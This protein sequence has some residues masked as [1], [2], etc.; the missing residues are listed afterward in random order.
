MKA[1]FRRLGYAALGLF[2]FLVVQT[3]LTSAASTPQKPTTVVAAQIPASY[4]DD[5]PID[6]PEI[7]HTVID[8]YERVS[9]N[10]V[11]ITARAEQ[12]D[13]F[14]R[15]RRVQ[16]GGSGFVI[17]QDGHIVTNHHVVRGATQLDVTLAD[18]S[19]YPGEVLGVDGVNDLA[20]VRLQA[21]A[22]TIEELSAVPLGA[23]HSLQVG[24]TVVAIGNPYGLER[25]A[26]KGIVSSLG[27]VRT[28]ETERQ[29]TNM[30]QTDAAINPGNS[31]GPLLNLSGEVIGINEQ[32]HV[33][34]SR[35]NIGIG[36][37][38]PVDTLVRY[39][40]DLLEGSE[41]RHAWLG[42][43]GLS[44][45]SLMAERHGLPV[46]RG[47]LVTSVVDGG[48]AEQAGLIAATP[49]GQTLD[50]DIVTAIDG[51]P[52]RK[53][54]DIAAYV[55]AAEPGWVVTLSVVR[56]GQA[57]QVPVSLGAWEDQGEP[58]GD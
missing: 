37:A 6:H 56:N 20:V 40:P 30:I 18:G 4:P 27:R 29:I 41:P 57:L 24:E 44:V 34:G 16:S 23:S 31:G 54:E 39:L 51:E 25:S 17:D 32:I 58:A 2:G 53:A 35:G 49:S 9:P 52:V 48:P 3:L 11:N 45:T 50:A 21:P 33:S 7:D 46:E 47:V 55:D 13:I 12:T 43:G 10:V 22:D 19:S 14:G 8:L 26:T 15:R 36:F 42:I 38:I 1:G 28:G 5:T